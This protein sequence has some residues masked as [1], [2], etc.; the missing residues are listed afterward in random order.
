[1]HKRHTF[2]RLHQYLYYVASYDG[3][4]SEAQN[5][6][7][8]FRA[9]RFSL[10]ENNNYHSQLSPNETVTWLLGAPMKKASRTPGFNALNCNLFTSCLLRPET[11][12]KII[13]L[14]T[15]NKDHMW[16]NNELRIWKLLIESGEAKSK[17]SWFEVFLLFYV[18]Q[19]KS[20][21]ERSLWIS[22]SNT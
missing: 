20:K 15:F 10:R 14:A 3:K 16:A 9:F 4:K 17:G 11:Q 22:A 13:R 1:M 5:H 18:V 8:T 12:H 7:N 21:V 6:A 19:A 2:A